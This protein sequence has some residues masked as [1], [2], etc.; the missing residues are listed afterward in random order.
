MK[1]LYGEWF[2]YLAVGWIVIILLIIGWE[3]WK[4]GRDE[5]TDKNLPRLRQLA[6][7]CR[8]WYRDWFGK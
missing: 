2:S 5:K 4:G 3:V 8:Y 7:A 6:D 1:V